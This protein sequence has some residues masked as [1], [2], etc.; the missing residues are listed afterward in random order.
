MPNLLI[1]PL[2]GKVEVQG[3]LIHF[4]AMASEEPDGLPGPTDWWIERIVELTSNLN[5]SNR[6]KIDFEL[7]HED[8]IHQAIRAYCQKVM[9]ESDY[10]Q[11]LR[12][13]EA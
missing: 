10:D 5:L 7:K 12:R 9:E 4:E 13:Q 3:T 8:E 6:F 2:K 11:S 1:T